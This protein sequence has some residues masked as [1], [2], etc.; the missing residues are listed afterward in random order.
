MMQTLSL[1]DYKCPY[2]IL[3]YSPI[4]LKHNGLHQTMSC[5][6][7]GGSR[8]GAWGAA[9]LILGEKEEMTEERVGRVSKS[10]LGPLLSSRSGSATGYLTS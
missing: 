3:A 1:D 5:V 6:A 9:P 4:L 8:G 10:K 2:K 7:S